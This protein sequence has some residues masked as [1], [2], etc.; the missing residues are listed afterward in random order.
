MNK[1][2]LL[3]TVAIAVFL[4]G[5][6][7]S[8]GDTG[9]IDP[10][11]TPTPAPSTAAPVITRIRVVTVNG[12]QGTTYPLSQVSATTETFYTPDSTTWEPVTNATI[13]VSGSNLQSNATGIQGYFIGSSY[14]V[15]SM[16]CQAALNGTD[17]MACRVFARNRNHLASEVTEGSRQYGFRLV[18]DGKKSNDVPI[19]VTP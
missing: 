7:G 18:V 2:V 14:Q 4:A 6:G 13:F 17:D 11:A 8:G 16:H 12:D 15:D 1:A 9:K 5:C 10:T 19:V 3:C